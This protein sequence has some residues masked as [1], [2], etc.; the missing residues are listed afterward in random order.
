MI[1]EWEGVRAP[2]HNFPFESPRLCKIL[3]FYGLRA[4][5]NCVSP[6]AKAA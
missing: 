4:L 2:F 3:P 1:N 5:R 6:E